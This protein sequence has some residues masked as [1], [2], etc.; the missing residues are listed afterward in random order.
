MLL[1]G[2]SLS[3]LPMQSSETSPSAAGE[4]TKAEPKADQPR[5]RDTPTA[6]SEDSFITKPL[7]ATTTTL[8]LDASADAMTRRRRDY[9]AGITNVVGQSVAARG[10][11]L[12]FV[13]QE[14]KPAGILQLF[15]P[16]APTRLG[17][18]AGSLVEWQP[19]RGA[20]PL[21]RTFVDDRTHEP[22]GML[23]LGSPKPRF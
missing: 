2:V 23:L 21:P 1:A 18:G 14:R 7:L 11:A 4:T 5:Q 12:Q 3:S 10:G 6:N 20:A 17:T 22:Q 9:D 8:S 13:V 16:F 15:N 19:G